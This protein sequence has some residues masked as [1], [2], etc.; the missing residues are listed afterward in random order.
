MKNI[1]KVNE[2]KSSIMKNLVDF[3]IW[4]VSIAWQRPVNTSI[5]FFLGSYPLYQIIKNMRPI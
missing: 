5:A 4:N 1:G 3:D 2:N